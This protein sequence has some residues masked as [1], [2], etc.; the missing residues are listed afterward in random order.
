MLINI[1]HVGVTDYTLVVVS[2]GKCADVDLW[3][4]ICINILF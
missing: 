4:T 3:I 1:V 2:D